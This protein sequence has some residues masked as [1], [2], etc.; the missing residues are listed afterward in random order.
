M[1]ITSLLVI[2]FMCGLFVAQV[3]QN[4]KREKEDKLMRMWEDW[5]DYFGIEKEKSE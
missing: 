1:Y 4:W 3:Y 2:G 5:E